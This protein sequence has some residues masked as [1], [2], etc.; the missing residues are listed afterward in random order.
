MGQYMISR[1]MRF[2]FFVAG[3]VI[4]AG[5]WLTGFALVH[6][7]IYIPATFFYFA[8]VTGICPGLIV[9]RL[10]LGESPKK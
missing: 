4:W 3:S 1:S 8:V 10:I 6:W 7:L 9:S 5:M 2:F